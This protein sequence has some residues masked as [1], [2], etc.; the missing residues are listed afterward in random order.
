M[1]TTKNVMYILTIIPCVKIATKGIPFVRSILKPNLGVENLDKWGKLWTYF[2][3]YWVSSMDFLST[4]N[5]HDED[6]NYSDL[7]KGP[8]I[9]WRVT[10]VR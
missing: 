1:A 2:N 7:K 5:I 9:L 8:I 4:W 10:I 3:S 6:D